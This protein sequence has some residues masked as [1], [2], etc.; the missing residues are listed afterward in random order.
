VTAPN[1]STLSDGAAALVLMGGTKMKELGLKPLAKIVS[2]A[3]A[4]RVRFLYLYR[5]Q[6]L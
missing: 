4:A 1:S 2:W 6:S 5:L 3:D